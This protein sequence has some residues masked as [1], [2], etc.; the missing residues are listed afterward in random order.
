MSE[1]DD[2]LERALHTR[3]IPQ[4]NAAR[5]RFLVKAAK[6]STRLVA[7]ELGVSQRTVQRWLK[8]AA[9]TPKPDA[10]KAIENAVKAKWQPRV[11]D[12]ARKAA[13]ANGFYLNAMGQF[14]YRS[15]A[16]STDD[17]RL[18]QITQ[19]LPGS[20]AAEL[21]AARDAGATESRQLDILAR[22]LQESYFKDGGR[23]ASGLS[24]EFNGLEWASFE[25]D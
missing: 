20:V 8:S 9:I 3:P 14:G 1:I 23:R 25:I 6:G 13:V 18:R 21:F 10:A 7:Q 4:S 2:G 5:I 16:G 11:R 19:K 17:P 15:A 12:R 24:V 22:G